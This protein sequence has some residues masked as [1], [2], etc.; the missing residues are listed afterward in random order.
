MD[1]IQY[2]IYRACTYVGS[3][4]KNIFPYTFSAAFNQNRNLSHGNLL[5]NNA[6]RVGNYYERFQEYFNQLDNIRKLV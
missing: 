1:T 3:I 6:K 4:S 5:E 2:N